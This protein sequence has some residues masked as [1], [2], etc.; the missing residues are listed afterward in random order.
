MLFHSCKIDH[1]MWEITL[2][3]GEQTNDAVGLFLVMR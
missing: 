1:F 3:G 2:P